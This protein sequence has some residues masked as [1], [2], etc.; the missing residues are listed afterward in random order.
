LPATSLICQRGN[1]KRGGRN[2]MA[3]SFGILLAKT[4]ETFICRDVARN[5]P[6][7][8]TGKHEAR[9]KK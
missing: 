2:S 4:T 9:G 1:T 7:M 3:I 6:N 5:V 8:S